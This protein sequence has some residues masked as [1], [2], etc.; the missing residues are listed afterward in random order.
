MNNTNS[1]K[2]RIKSITLCFYIQSQSPFKFKT[3]VYVCVF[4]VCAF[5]ISLI[6]VNYIDYKTSSVLEKMFKLHHLLR[7]FRW[8]KSHLLGLGATEY[9]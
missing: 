2:F 6:K 5:P 7:H 9:F 3:G 8:V 4:Y 1:I